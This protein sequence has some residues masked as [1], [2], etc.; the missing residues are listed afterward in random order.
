ML[1]QHKKEYEVHKSYKRST[2]YNYECTEELNTAVSRC[3]IPARSLS[4][5]ARGRWPETG[6]EEGEEDPV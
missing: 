4:L 2:E 5:S 6:G 3:R 1:S